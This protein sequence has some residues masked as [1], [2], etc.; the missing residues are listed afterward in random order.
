MI[1]IRCP[2]VLLHRVGGRLD[3]KASMGDHV[4]AV[5]HPAI[6]RAA[7]IHAIGA[8]ASAFWRIDVAPLTRTELRA[9]NRGWTLRSSGSP[10]C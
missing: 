9:R 5:T 7:I 4:V 1:N 10:M 8:A 6:V 2:R 3:A